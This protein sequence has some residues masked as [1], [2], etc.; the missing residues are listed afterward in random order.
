[1]KETQIEQ[2]PQEELLITEEGGFSEDD[3]Q[4]IERQI[5]RLVEENKTPITDK[6]FAIHPEKKGFFFPLTVNIVAL[7]AIVGGFF[8][9]SWYFEQKKETLS[10]AAQ[11]YLSAE[12]RLIAELKREAESKILAKDEQIS[13]IQT[14]LEEID[15]EREDLQQNMDKRIQEREEAMKKQLDRQL[16]LEKSRLVALGRSEEDIADQLRNLE[17]KVKNEQVEEL[18]AFR[19]QSEEAIREK[20]K[21]LEQNRQLTQEILAGARTERLDLEEKSQAREE[22]LVEMYEEEKAE[23]AERATEVEQQLQDITVLQAREQLLSDQIIG[24]YSVIEQKLAN[25]FF[26]DAKTD[27]LQL[28]TMLFDSSIESIPSIASRRKADL[29]L[30]D[31]LEELIES[32]A[33][34]AE[35]KTTDSIMDAANI[36][37][38]AR[39]VVKR[40]DEAYGNGQMAEAG[41]LY[42][43][44]IGLPPS[45]SRAYTN[46]EEIQ[47]QKQKETLI[48]ALADGNSLFDKSDITG[49]VSVYMQAVVTAAGDNS[50]LFQQAIDGISQALEY[51]YNEII[52]AKDISIS[53]ISSNLE[54]REAFLSDTEDRLAGEKN[55]TRNLT[56]NLDEASSVI[57]QGDTAIE[58][59]N[60]EAVTLSDAIEELK[61]GSKTLSDNLTAAETRISSLTEERDELTARSKTL[62]DNL[63]AAETRISSLTDERDELTA[64][65]QNLTDEKNDLEK[66]IDEK[67]WEIVFLLGDISA[68]EIETEDQNEQITNLKSLVD[69]G[70]E[71]N[72]AMI[73]QN[74]L[75]SK[76]LSALQNQYDSAN[77]LLSAS[78]AKGVR[79]EDDLERANENILTLSSQVQNQS[80]P[81]IAETAD[82]ELLKLRETYSLYKIALESLL[83]SPTEENIR[84]S[85]QVLSTFFERVNNQAFPGM[86]SIWQQTDGQL[87]EFERDLSE[88]YGQKNALN[89]VIRYIDSVGSQTGLASQIAFDALARRNLL[90]K[91]AFDGISKL[92]TEG[93]PQTQVSELVYIGDVDA[94]AS[95]KVTI[96]TASD[97][98]VSYDDSILI[99]RV[100]SDGEEVSVAQGIVTGRE[101]DTI[102][103]DLRLYLDPNPPGSDDKAYLESYR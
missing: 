1:M 12:G 2:D 91:R 86:F 68:L 20:E 60:R 19:Q 79:L 80:S 66:A 102:T 94:F 17:E 55:I 14:Q 5:D 77:E 42:V 88:E 92:A 75:S 39:G 22:E 31:S 16:T 40:A 96:E 58:K 72:L 21:E 46:I 15:R 38:S 25:G 99:K 93:A 48:S 47:D 69:S 62:N 8:L 51:R 34:L 6:L 30:I 84:E 10:L 87:L 57:S 82:I 33:A 53:A 37:T 52:K 44:A 35:A 56:A 32:R 65:N 67:G 85:K 100:Q 78:L 83:E 18:N 41:R 64:G 59:L 95:G 24:T 23:L 103:V 3:K 73:N 101:E 7:A 49:A 63:A 81:E 90:F 76:E 45:L 70:T 98:S 50:T 43:E 28:R 74:E 26:D 9:V 11:S 71:E 97:L 89:E 61:A 29:F 13:E 27:L 54:R 4:D 36:L